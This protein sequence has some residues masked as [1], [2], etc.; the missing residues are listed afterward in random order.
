[1]LGRLPLCPTAAGRRRK[2]GDSTFAKKGSQPDLTCTYLR[3]DTALRF[4]EASSEPESCPV[5]HL[6]RLPIITTSRVWV[7]QLHLRLGPP[8]ELV[9]SFPA[10]LFR[11]QA[12]LPN[13]PW[14]KCPGV[15]W[16]RG[17]RRPTG[18][19]QGSPW[20]T[21]VLAGARELIWPSGAA[22][23]RARYRLDG[24]GPGAYYVQYSYE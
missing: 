8:V 24:V 15:G 5:W 21:P 20:W 1:M 6:I 4:G 12:G 18:A 19:G 14:G 9:P 10:P 11:Q 22:L 16:L 17:G 13:C 3:Q 7:Q 23:G 2:A